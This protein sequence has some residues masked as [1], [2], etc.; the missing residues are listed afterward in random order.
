MNK[1]LGRDMTL[2]SAV[3]RLFL[4]LLPQDGPIM[5]SSDLYNG[6]TVNRSAPVNAG[7]LGIAGVRAMLHSLSIWN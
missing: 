2:S 1:Y 7:P 5:S 3:D 6:G 4:I